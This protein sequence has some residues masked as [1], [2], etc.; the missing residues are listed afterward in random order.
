VE[1]P[2][3]RKVL[4]RGVVDTAESN[5]KFEYLNNFE[6]ISENENVLLCETGP[7]GRLL[8][9]NHRVKNLTRLSLWV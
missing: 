9:K 8:T 2:Y 4:S 6:V 5:L 7:R 3:L 1:L